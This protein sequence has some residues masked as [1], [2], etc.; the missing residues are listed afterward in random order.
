MHTYTAADTIL[1]SMDRVDGTDLGRDRPE[2]GPDQCHTWPESGG[3]SNSVRCTLQR[4][5]KRKGKRLR[6]ELE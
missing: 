6:R 1:C 5:K 2:T 4:R 3:W